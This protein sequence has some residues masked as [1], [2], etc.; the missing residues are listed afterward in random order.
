MAGDFLRGSVS[1][2]RP[3]LLIRGVDRCE[4]REQKLLQFERASIFRGPPVVERGAPPHLA[5]GD[6][7]AFEK[8]FLGILGGKQSFDH[9]V[10]LGGH[11]HIQHRGARFLCL[12]AQTRALLGVN[13]IGIQNSVAAFLDDLHRH[14]LGD[15]PGL[16][17]PLSGCPQLEP[18]IVSGHQRRTDQRRDTF[19]DRGLSGA[20]QASSWEVGLIDT[21]GQLSLYYGLASLVFIGGSLIPHGGQNPLEAT[22]LGK[23]V[24][25]GRFMDNFAVI[26]HQL[27]AHHAAYQVAGGDELIRVME[28]FIAQ[29]KEAAVMGQQAKEVTERFR[30]ATQRATDVITP[31]LSGD[32][33]WP[34]GYG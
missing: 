27:L 34:R 16:V 5:N 30:G 8:G 4:K 21:F 33:A 23:P 20:N 22:S 19:R 25:F 1:F 24:I 10:S 28:H 31:Y 2:D 9:R 17:V 26:A 6:R 32:R 7:R 14:I 29:P 13:R 3:L 18:D 12:G 11:A 15:H